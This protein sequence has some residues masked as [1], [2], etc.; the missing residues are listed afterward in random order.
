MIVLLGPHSRL[1]PG[2]GG[3][4]SSG[5][6]GGGGSSVSLGCGGQRLCGSRPSRV[7]RRNRAT[8]ADE[9]D[10]LLSILYKAT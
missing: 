5:G 2:G 1:R 9:E 3:G 7:G 4:G 6:G 8:A 10:S